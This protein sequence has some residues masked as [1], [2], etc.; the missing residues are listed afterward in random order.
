MTRS[1]KT[2]NV[3]KNICREIFIKYFRVCERRDRR[4]E[5][6]AVQQTRVLQHQAQGGEIQQE[7]GVLL[8]QEWQP[9][10]QRQ[11]RQENSVWNIS[12][13]RRTLLQALDRLI[14]YY[15]K[16]QFHI[17]R[18]WDVEDNT[19][20]ALKVTYIPRWFP[21]SLFHLH[22]RRPCLVSF[23]NFYCFLEN[24]S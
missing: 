18:S 12:G 14:S 23:V 6:K 24:I 2:W 16:Y 7:H 17:L 4:E 5:S 10:P 19:I 1:Q 11:R 20:A 9:P 3:F 15:P 21:E 13:G 22:L 8:R